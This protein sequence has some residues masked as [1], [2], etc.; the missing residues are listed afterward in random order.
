M[1]SIASPRRTE[2]GAGQRDL[3]TRAA[4]TVI[5][6]A[7]LT[8]LLVTFRPFQPAG[9][10]VGSD[11][12]DIVNQLGF[13]GLGAL[14]A[15][16]LA[17]F[18]DRRVLSALISPSWFVLLALFALSVVNATYF[19]SAVRAAIFTLIGI[20]SVAAV[21]TLPR[22]AESFSA[23][24][25]TS[26]LVVIGLSY[27]G[28][29]LMPDVAVHGG[30]GFEP[31]HD[32]FWR[33]SF[34][35]KNIAGPVM[36]CLSFAGLYLMRRGKL[37]LGGAIFLLAMLFMSNTG[38]KT[39]AGLVPAAILLVALPP[40]IGMRFLTPLLFL[41]AIVGTALATVGIVFVDAL[42]DM[43]ATLAPDLT[44]TGRTSLWA[45][46]GEMIAL[47]PLT[48]FGYE[49]FWA[50]PFLFE[51]DQPFDR[52]WDIRGIVHGHNG[53]LY[54]AVTMGLPAMVAAIFAFVLAPLRDYLRTPRLRENIY[55]ADFFMMVLLFTC[56]NAFLESF[57]FRRADPVWL[58]LV[59]GAIGMRLV[60]RFP[61]RTG[62]VR[63]D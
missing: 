59:M 22:D 4:A 36:A 12:G 9:G 38:S 42:R 23:V 11:S 26:A 33:G 47:K 40:L 14:S 28:L 52:G 41:L 27:A 19:D 43:A 2:V 24:L 18:V 63:P 20:V 54:V 17:A 25:A 3:V 60:A 30:D 61:V 49:S 6:T 29:V 50:T 56:L 37:W 8:V 7:I 39:T 21:L 53:Y 13:G 44:Y 46:S 58:F 48:G 57:F 34:S 62:P 10:A 1:N 5:A 31:Q 15:L 35:H 16:A 32:G 45:F 55:L 51:S